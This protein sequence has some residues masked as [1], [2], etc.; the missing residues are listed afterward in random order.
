MAVSR[1]NTLLA[2][3][4][5]LVIALVLLLIYSVS[6]TQAA[7]PA[8]AKGPANL[9]ESLVA[10]KSASPQHVQ[11][12]GQLT[13]TLYVT[14]SGTVSLTATITDLLP[15]QVAPGGLR[16]WATF[17]NPGKAWSE[18]LVVTV[19]EGYTGPVTNH[20]RVTTLEGPQGEARVT[21]CANACLAFLPLVLRNHM[22]GLPPREWDPRLDDLGVALD[23]APIEPGEPHWRLVEGRW[24]DPVESAGRHHIFIEVLD[25]N[26][27]RAAGQPVV[28][29]WSDGNLTL[30]VEPG[31]PPEWGT[32]FPMFATLGGYNARVGGGAPSDR[33]TGMGMGTPEL[34]DFTIHTSFY[35]TYRWIP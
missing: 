24:A 15:A 9:S 21:T 26:E 32:N 2:L 22:S 18:T 33:V 13:Y 11:G 4:A 25:E 29:E 17:V 7:M 8:P 19:T 6:T 30:I 10:A 27:D 23:P 35:L 20:L 34:P 28:I 12:G 16:T 5:S 14:N 31:P 3:V 1:E